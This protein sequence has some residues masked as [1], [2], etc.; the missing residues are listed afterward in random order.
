M[1]G[2]E[3]MEDINNYRYKWR[4]ED[5]KRPEGCCYDCRIKYDQFPDMTISDE[6]W[7]L[8]N[9]TFI[10][11]SGLL[12]PT[13]ISNRLDYLNKWYHLKIVEAE[14]EDEIT[15]DD[16]K[17]DSIED[18]AKYNV[19]TYVLEDVNKRITD[20]LSSGGKIDDPYIKQQFRY[21]ENVINKNKSNQIS[22]TMIKGMFR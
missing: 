21:V 9:P 4:Y 12:C 19:P 22:K 3:F 16:V 5:D 8:I 11:G 17:I 15:M 10:E 2:S 18:I 20:W 6:L 13:C 1:E 7:K 14:R